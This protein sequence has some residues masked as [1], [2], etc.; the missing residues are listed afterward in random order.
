MG[1]H[2]ILPSAYLV[3][4]ALLGVGLGRRKLFQLSFLWVWK[5]H[6]S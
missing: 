3:S 1:N 6:K 2:P 5:E 4:E